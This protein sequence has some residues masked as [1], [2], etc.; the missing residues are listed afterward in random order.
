MLRLASFL[1][2]SM[3]LL[4]PYAGAQGQPSTH[5]RAPQG[6]N[7]PPKDLAN[8]LVQMA[9]AAHVPI[10]AELVWTLP[11]I[12]TAEGI[13]LTPERLN[14]LVEKSPGYE[15]KMEGK[16]VHFYN[17]KLRESRFNFLNFKIPRFTVP[18]DV[19]TLQLWFPGQAQGLLKE[20]AAQGGATS[21]WG[22][23]QLE[24]D[25]LRQV[26]L[27]NVTPL[28]VLVHVAN[29]SPTF[30]IAVA[31]PSIPATKNAAIKQTVVWQWG[32]LNEKLHALGMQPP[33]QK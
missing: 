4:S 9:R 30:Y 29:E 11:E 12:P 27:E 21:G 22:D 15:W 18:P 2:A 28:D 5:R 3:L 1:F 23:P 19:S 16:V 25:K 20:Y 26:S 24:K 10:T 17:K 31:F 6:P 14:E 32:S 7:L 13:P 33:P 8:A